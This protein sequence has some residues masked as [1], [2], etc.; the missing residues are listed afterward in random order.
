MRWWLAPTVVGLI[1]HAAWLLVPCDE[2]APDDRALVKLTFALALGAVVVLAPIAVVTDADG[3][4]GAMMTIAAMAWMFPSGAALLTW[5]D[6]ADWLPDVR[7]PLPRA[8]WL[9]GAI[10]I[11]LSTAMLWS[12]L[13]PTVRW[14]QA[15]WH[16]S[17]YGRAG[18]LR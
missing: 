17:G 7:V 9:R 1:V 10:T 5:I 14:T 16:S 4:L 8:R 18:H 13:Y 3:V 15:G 11:A 6:R 2:R 12:I